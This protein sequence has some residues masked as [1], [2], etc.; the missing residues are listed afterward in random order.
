MIL[1]YSH[2][3]TPRLKYTFKT[4]FTDV[5]QV[6]VNF[7]DNA[8]EFENYDG[9]K[10][11]YSNS[12][13]NSGL[14]F[15]S[16]SILF[17][18][19]I[20]EQNIT[21]FEFENNKC[22]YPVGK[23]SEFPF[24]PF[25]ASFY[26]ISRYEEYLPHIKDTHERFLATESLAFQNNFLD[27]PLVNIWINEIA[28]RIENYSNGF[29]FP[30]RTFEFIP[31]IDIDNAYA[32]K[33]KG[34]IRIIGGLAKSLFKGH[35]F[36]ERLK[37]IFGKSSDPYN[38]YQYQYE[39]HEKY[40]TSPIYFFL[41]GDYGVND[42]NISVKNKTFQSLIKSISDYS[43]I[44][45]HPSYASNNNIKTLTKEINRLQT[46]THRNVTRSRQHFLKLNLPNTYRNLI[47]NDIQSD[48]TMGYAEKSGFRASI[49]SPYFFYDLDT[50][51]ET[52]LQLFPFTVM[53][54]TYQYYE[55][56]SPEKA[57]EHIIEL[58]EKVRKVR[59]TFISAWHNESL[60]DEGIW[61]G[62]KI[63]YEKMLKVALTKN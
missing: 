56:T 60:S 8:D 25:A 47:D 17:E 9:I 35:N 38:T 1:I 48:Y 23:D 55:N 13:L 58:M 21:I 54:A 39:I 32:Y 37:V 52:K 43:K 27:T 63:V 24:D 4:I 42:K 31:T 53:E 44:G 7:T 36:M 61:E 33:H 46:I 50:E 11:N 10:I 62:W 20:K 59:G 29:Q 22:F 12:K 49:C 28:K 15:Q 14:F 2:K 6:S 18:I 45:I 40:N 26:L 19:G 30:K 41:L 5:L 51:V 57:I 34:F 16:T 3:L